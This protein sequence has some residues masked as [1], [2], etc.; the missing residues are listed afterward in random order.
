MQP[1]T[2]I[3]CLSHHNTATPTT[4][5]LTRAEFEDTPFMREG[6]VYVDG[7]DADGRSVVVSSSS[8]STDGGDGGGSSGSSSSRGGA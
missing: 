1:P 3:L 2:C 5:N 7:N 6:W 4:D 8:G